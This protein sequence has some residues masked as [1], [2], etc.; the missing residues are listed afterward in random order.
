MF[1]PA[2]VKSQPG[3]ATLGTQRRDCALAR[4]IQ[5]LLQPDCHHDYNRHANESHR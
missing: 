3:K 4:Q 5:L 2:A 1:T